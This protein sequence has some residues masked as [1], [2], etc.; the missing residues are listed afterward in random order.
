MQTSGTLDMRRTARRLR[1]ATMSPMTDTPSTQRGADVGGGRPS[2]EKIRRY[3]LVRVKLE[4]DARRAR[5]AERYAH[6]RRIYD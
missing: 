1:S 6:L 4:S 5:G 3:R 2:E